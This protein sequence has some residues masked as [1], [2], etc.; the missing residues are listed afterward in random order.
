ML[1]DFYSHFVCSC[2]TME[3]S[4]KEVLA[5]LRT[6]EPALLRTQLEQAQVQ[7]E[8]NTPMEIEQMLTADQCDIIERSRMKCLL[9]HKSAIA[10]LVLG[11]LP[12]DA[13]V[14]Q[15][16]GLN[17]VENAIQSAST[18]NDL[19]ANI[20]ETARKELETKKLHCKEMEHANH[21]LRAKL[22]QSNVNQV[23][24]YSNRK[25]LQKRLSDKKKEFDNKGQD[26]VQKMANLM[27][28]HFAKPAEVAGSKP[29]RK[30]DRSSVEPPRN[31]FSLEE[32]VELLLDRFLDKS[33]DSWIEVSDRFWPPYIELLHRNGV[34]VSQPGNDKRIKLNQHLF[35]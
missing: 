24:N 25:L 27:R 18:I 34:T 16:Y 7:H 28:T 14:L 3:A 15:S 11:T 8:N 30:E 35:F 33:Q 31:C 10:N 29:K 20:E 1:S 5:V 4:E 21:L 12:T 22:E 32:I 17:E 23:E 26:L 9:G 2:V 19:L 6:M 13:E